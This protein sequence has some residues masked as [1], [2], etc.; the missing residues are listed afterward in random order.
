[1][2]R[3]GTQK[4]AYEERPEGYEETSYVDSEGKGFQVEGTASAQMEE[5][6]WEISDQGRSQRK[7]I[8]ADFQDNF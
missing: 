6:N 1:M 5:G 8:F 3:E 2:I 7:E 4:A